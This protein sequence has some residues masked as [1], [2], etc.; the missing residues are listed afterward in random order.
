VQEKRRYEKATVAWRKL[1]LENIRRLTGDDLIKW[2]QEYRTNVRAYKKKEFKN[3]I[4]KPRS[5][6][7]VTLDEEIEEIV[8]GD[9]ASFANHNDNNKTMYYSENIY[10][11]DSGAS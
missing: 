1:Q 5:V 10:I 3:K 4:K 6:A 8:V 11:G 2:K 7:L 9:D